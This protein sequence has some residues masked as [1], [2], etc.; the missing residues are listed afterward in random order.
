MLDSIMSCLRFFDS[1][2]LKLLYIF[3][4]IFAFL[5]WF[6]EVTKVNVDL[7]SDGSEMSFLSYFIN[8]FLNLFDFV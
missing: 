4:E 3:N 7:V 6:Y 8:L 1:N 2:P 5:Q